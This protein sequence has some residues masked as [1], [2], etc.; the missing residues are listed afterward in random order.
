VKLITER[1]GQYLLRNEELKKRVQELEEQKKCIMAENS[2][3]KRQNFYL[4]NFT[5]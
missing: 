5:K 1:L 4:T 2:R 3:L